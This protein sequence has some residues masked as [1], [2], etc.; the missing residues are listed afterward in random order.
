MPLLPGSSK[1]VISQNIKEMMQS[2]H[3]QDQAVAAALRKAG[4]SNKGKKGHPNR[5][6]NLGKFHHPKG[7]K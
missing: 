1:S 5:P 2:G 7:S 6:K 4:K 3:K